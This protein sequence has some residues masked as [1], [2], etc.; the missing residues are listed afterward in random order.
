MFSVFHSL[1]PPDN[2]GSAFQNPATSAESRKRE[3]LKIT[4]TH[5]IRSWVILPARHAVWRGK[6]PLC[7]ILDLSSAHLPRS[8]GLRSQDKSGAVAWAE[9]QEELDGKDGDF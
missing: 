8:A 4:A 9:K 3:I 2:G 7:G 1:V 5:T 6:V